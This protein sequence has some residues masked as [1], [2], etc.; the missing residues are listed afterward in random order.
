MKKLAFSVVALL[1][2]GAGVSV[3]AAGCSSSSSNNGTPAPDTGTAADSTTPEDGGADTGTPDDS[4]TGSDAPAEAGACMTDASGALQVLEP[5]DDGGVMENTACETCIAS[6]CGA[7][8]TACIQDCNMVPD[9]N[10]DA[11]VPACGAYAVCV[12]SAFLTNLS[13]YV[14]DAGQS[15]GEP[16][17]LAAAQAGCAGSFASTSTGSGNALIGC[18]AGMCATQCV[19]Q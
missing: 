4:S 11:S 19:G 8:Q 3:A 18:I 12:Y 16:A 15:V 14:M 13:A 17:D 2:A 1:V 7:A 9:P 5:T 6:S 10:S